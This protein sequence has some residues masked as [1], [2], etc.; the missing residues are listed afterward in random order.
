M[1]LDVEPFSGLPRV[2]RSIMST[3]VVRCAVTVTV[4]STSGKVSC[5]VAVHRD[6]LGTEAENSRCVTLGGCNIRKSE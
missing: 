1:H 4:G 6:M 3:F 2:R 5:P